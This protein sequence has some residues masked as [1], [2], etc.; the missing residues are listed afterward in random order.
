MAG[1][2]MNWLVDTMATELKLMM[3]EFSAIERANTGLDVILSLHDILLGVIFFDKSCRS[4]EF[5]L[6]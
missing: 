4:L 6:I 1:F 3:D 5:A 2:D